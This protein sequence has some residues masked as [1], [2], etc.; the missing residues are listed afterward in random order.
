MSTAGLVYTWTAYTNNAVDNSIKSSSKEPLNFK[1]DPYALKV[2]SL[3][4]IQLTVYATESKAFSYAEVQVYVEQ[5]QIVSVIAGG[6]EKNIKQG[7]T[8]YLDASDS[9]DSDLTVDETPTFLYKWSCMTISPDL[10]EECGL[11]LSSPDS[12]SQSISYKARDDESTESVFLIS[13][14][15]YDTTRSSSSS[16]KV[17]VLSLANPTLSLLSPVPLK[18]NPSS[19]ILIEG[20]IDDISGTF[21]AIWKVTDT[22]GNAIDVNN[23]VLAPTTLLCDQVL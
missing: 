2:S 12:V 7:R 8:I 19:K 3:Y 10:S 1:L 22:Y 15:V 5:N 11:I 16:V 17:S 18:V 21:D 6:N 9:Y 13:V 4:I 14:T 23:K 20:F